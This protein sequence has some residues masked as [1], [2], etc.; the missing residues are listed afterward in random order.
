M[1]SDGS[2]DY[3]IR[4]LRKKLFDI[5]DESCEHR[6]VTYVLRPGGGAWSSVYDAGAVQVEVIKCAL[7]GTGCISTYRF[8]CPRYANATHLL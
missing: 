2:L 8:D 7:T 3:T 1:T 4:E 5:R 6:E